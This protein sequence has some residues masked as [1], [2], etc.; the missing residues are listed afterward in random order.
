[1]FTT[2]AINQD[3]K[4]A[5]ADTYD[6]RRRDIDANTWDPEQGSIHKKT[7]QIWGD[8]GDEE[9]GWADNQFTPQYDPTDDFA[10]KGDNN[11]LSRRQARDVRNKNKKYNKRLAKAEEAGFKSWEEM[12][13]AENEEKML[14]K[15]RRKD[16]RDRWGDT[17]GQRM[18]NKFNYMMDSKAMQTYGKVGQAL[19]KGAGIVNDIFDARREK[20]EQDKLLVSR[21]ADDVYGVTS[22][23]TLSRGE[24]DEN[25]GI[26]QP[27]DKV[28]SRWGKYGIELPRA[29]NTV[30]TDAMKTFTHNRPIYDVT[31]RCL[32]EGC[33]NRE[34]DASHDFSVGLG[35]GLGKQNQNYMGDAKLWGGYSFNPEPGTK[36][37][38][39]SQEG[40]AGYLGANIGGSM[41][42]PEEV[43]NTGEGNPEFK[44]FANAVATLGWKDEWK[45]KNDYLA[46]LTGRDKDPLQL[47]LGAY[48]Q[49]PL[50]GDQGPEIGGYANIDNL[51]FTAGYIPGQGMNY[52]LGIGI[53]IRE[54]G[55]E[56]K[57]KTINVNSDMYYELIAAGAD[58]EII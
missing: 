49:H 29:Q 47:G 40:L 18:G 45:P 53:P 38:R 19:V 35:F 57:Q 1:M 14:K 46:Y 54:D 24:H 32:Y 33:S 8:L 25:T 3:M 30:E 27:D 6:V 11:T 42:L 41:I 44:S 36:S 12:Q 9:M 10:F 31:G 58:L 37:F 4:T 23:D 52:G 2:N 22:A 28:I 13:T 7:G 17:W 55:G 21:S 15:Q 16:K 39:G 50:M 34:Y 48:Y 5:A 26:F 20:D 56:E 43:I 51:N